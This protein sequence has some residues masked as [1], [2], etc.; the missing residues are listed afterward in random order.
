MVKPDAYWLGA[1]G[2]PCVRVTPPA[3]VAALQ[4]EVERLREAG[5]KLYR[6]Y[7]NV[8]EIGRDRIIAL[9]GSCDPVDVMEGGDPVLIAARAAL[10][11]TP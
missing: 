2:G 3:E 10:A 5:Q 7:V 4:A 6:G 9:G 11:P 1:Y 8:L